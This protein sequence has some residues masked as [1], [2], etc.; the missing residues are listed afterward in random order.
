MQ[1]LK[2]KKNGINFKFIF[3]TIIFIIIFLVIIN[4]VLKYK[5]YIVEEYKDYDYVGTSFAKKANPI[6]LNNI[7]I[8]GIFEDKFVTSDKYYKYS[9]NKQGTILSTY[10]L[11]G[12]AGHYTLNTINNANGNYYGYI[13]K[14][15]DISEYLSVNEGTVYKVEEIKDNLPEY[16]KYV[17]QATLKYSYLNSS[18][19]IIKAYRCNSSY[20]IT[21]INSDNN[22]AYAT[23][24]YV[25]ETGN[26][27][28]VKYNYLKNIEK[29]DKFKIYFLKFVTDLDNDN[30]IELVISETT[31]NTTKYSVLEK[32]KNKFYEILQTEV[33]N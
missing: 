13:D 7:I 16:E 4:L 33:L 24:V 9:K 17:K 20:I 12:K 14:V 22:G 1:R 32:N 2:K 28:I 21:A 5:N 3:F 30:N 8:G 15:D 23:I 27:N 31:K 10:T 19:K 11:T 25:D 18:V 26:S 29:P 6:I